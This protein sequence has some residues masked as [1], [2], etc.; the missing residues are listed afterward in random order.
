MA[1]SRTQRWLERLG[2]HRPELRAWALYDWANSVFWTTVIQIFPV[3]YVNVA[4]A[5]L[6]RGPGHHP[7]RHAP[8]PSPWSLI[9]LLSPLL[10]AM[11]DYAGIKKKM[12]AA[13]LVLGI[14]STAAPV[15]RLPGDW[16]L[17][18]ALFMLANIGVDR[19]HRVLRSRCCPTSRSEE[20]VDRVST[21]GLRARLPRRRP[22][23]GLQPGHDPEADWFGIAGRRPP[24]CGSR[25]S[26]SRS[27]GWSSRSRSSARVPEPPRRRRSRRAAG[28]SPLRVGFARLGETFRELRGY[29]QAFLMLLAFLIYNDG[30]STIIRMA[31]PYG[32]EIGIAQERA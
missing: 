29:R 28:Q 17:A 13:F 14:S 7:L 32:T 12:L 26:P 31:A 24:R 30:I 15:L 9:A 1:L 23:A 5:D 25:S 4:A 6:P 19:H 16:V 11:A 8:P 3:Y 18:A 20:E 27:G 22:A 10:G 2:L 21:A